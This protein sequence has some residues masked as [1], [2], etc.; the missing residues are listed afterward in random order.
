ML[1]IIISHKADLD[2]VA[3]AALMMRKF[4]KSREPFMIFMRDYEDE[5]E[6]IPSTLLG[7]SDCSV[8]ISDISIMLK[9]FDEIV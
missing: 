9:G 1:N 4:I 3:S 5:S 7:L 8:Y 2:G 6:I